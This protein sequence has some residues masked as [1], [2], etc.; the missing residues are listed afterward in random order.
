MQPRGRLNHRL[1]GSGFNTILGVQQML[2]FDP[3]SGLQIFGKR[4]DVHDNVAYIKTKLK[5]F[6]TAEMRFQ[7]IFNVI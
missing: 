7:S 4:Y 1:S 3:Y 5:R 2:M 6:F